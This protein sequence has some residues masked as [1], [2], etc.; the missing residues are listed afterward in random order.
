MTLGINYIH[1][2]VWDEITYSISNANG[3]GLSNSITNL[4]VNLIIYPCWSQITKAGSREHFGALIAKIVN[5][6]VDSSIANDLPVIHFHG[7]YRVDIYIQNVFFLKCWKI[8]NIIY[9]IHKSCFIWLINVSVEGWCMKNNVWTWMARRFLRS[10][11]C[12]RSVYF[13]TKIK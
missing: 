10:V 7:N 13:T 8:P 2:K 12:Y 3:N 6:E 5:E 4:I 11:E 1:Y 9:V